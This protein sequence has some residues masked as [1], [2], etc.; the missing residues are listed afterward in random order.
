M[1]NCEFRRNSSTCLLYCGHHGVRQKLSANANDVRLGENCRS[2]HR[3]VI[4]I[5]TTR[6][7]RRLLNHRLLVLASIVAFA[8]VYY[9]A[10]SKDG[11][12]RISLSSAYVAFA[13][14]V[15]TLAIGPINAL[16]GVRLPVSND[17]RRDT[18]I[19]ACTWSIFH[20]VVGLQ[21]HLRGRMVEYFLYPSGASLVA[22]IRIDMFGM[23]NYFGLLA[24]V[25][26]VVLAAISNDW[27][28]RMLGAPRW[29]RLQQLNYIL[30]TI[31]VVH[32]V[33][34]Q[35]VEK[36]IPPFALAIGFLAGT[37]LTLQTAR[38][39]FRSAP[40]QSKI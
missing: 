1:R 10:P 19:W 34:Y 36:R 26:A 39:L 9:V 3:R 16:R 17:F 32:A 28:L 31:A 23:A 21:V 25:L 18:G 12:A 40:A 37:A 30:F 33:L 4:T 29:K 11:L 14:I 8:G 24:A 27:S 13:L 5:A 35:I 15:L 7:K 2:R 20:T 22:R 38:A 6:L